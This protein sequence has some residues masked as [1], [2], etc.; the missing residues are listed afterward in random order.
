MDLNGSDQNSGRIGT[1][2]TGGF[3]VFGGGVGSSDYGNDYT[4]ASDTENRPAFG[5]GFGPNTPA[6]GGGFGSNTVN[7]QASNAGRVGTMTGIGST[8]ANEQLAKQNQ[9]AGWT[10][11]LSNLTN[12]LPT[13]SK[14]KDTHGMDKN[15]F[16]GLIAGS[17]YEGADANGSYVGVIL[18]PGGS[19]GLSG[20][21]HVPGKKLWE[22]DTPSTKSTNNTV[23]EL[24]IKVV[25][26]FTSPGGIR[27]PAPTKKEC[28]DFAQKCSSLNLLQVA[29]LLNQ[30][31]DDHEW[32]V[33]LKALYGIEAL[34]KAENKAVTEFYSE[35]CENI[36]KQSESVQESVRQ[37]AEKVAKLL[38]FD[39]GD[40][41]QYG[42][43]LLE[44]FGGMSISTSSPSTSKTTRKQINFVPSSGSTTTTN[45]NSNDA[46]DFFDMMND[47]S[48]SNS[49]DDI[50]SGFEVKN[51]QPTP[52]QPV[53]QKTTRTPTET[54]PRVQPSQ[55]TPSSATTPTKSDLLDLDTLLSAPT[56]PSQKTTTTTPTSI[57]YT[58]PVQQPI[59]A[60]PT[61]PPMYQPYG[62][63]PQPGVPIYP[64][65]QQPYYPPQTFANVG[66]IPNRSNPPPIMPK[67]SQSQAFDFINNTQ[68]QEQPKEEK[69]SFDFVK[70]VY[71]K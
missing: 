31:L 12:Y 42:P 33:R 71:L 44:D 63:V 19:S 36:L 66:T 3:G 35:N 52:K 6:F 39:E 50:L 27:K 58:V 61:Y 22:T 59:Y 69:D 23:G 40:D 53:Q 25:N 68:P 21:S 43:T 1:T 30:K 38:N 64:V 5:G 46:S 56:I 47:N 17:E 2:P 4:H 15:N 62:V 29:E 28:T 54:K 16:P 9:S 34:L 20:S 32:I 65:Y 41:A 13:W 7:N 48:T 8:F 14:Q 24:E 57:P 49:G 37:Q 45:S 67:G 55:K 51:N 60:I 26:E 18:P 70:Q 10:G 11:T